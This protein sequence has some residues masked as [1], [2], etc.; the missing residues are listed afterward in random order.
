[1][2]LTIKEVYMVDLSVKY[3]GLDLKNPVVIS[4]HAPFI[5]RRELWTDEELSEWDMEL[6]GKYYEGGVAALTTGSIFSDEM[7]KGRGLQRFAPISTKGFA[8]REAFLGIATMPDALWPHTPG[9]MAIEKAK[10]KFKDM[11][12]IA[13]IMAE[14]QDP[15]AWGNLAL[16]AQQAGA[17]AVECNLGSVMMMKTS[18]EALTGIIEKRG[19][20]SGAIIGLVPEVVAEII[21]GIKKKVS[22]PHITKIT[23]ELGMFGLLSAVPLYK[24]AGTNALECIH[25]LMVVPAPDIYN[26]G[27]TTLPHLTKSTWWALVGPADRQLTYRDVPTVAK[28]FPE[29]DVAACG[30]LVTPE[31]CIEAM[32][33]GAKTVYL[34]AGIFW[35]GMSFPRKVIKFME[36][37]ME[38]QGYKTVYDFIG[39]GLKYVVEMGEAQEELKKQ[40][41]VVIAAVDYDKCVGPDTCRV[42]IDN[43]CVATYVE[44]E[45]VK[46]DPRRCC[47][48][49]LCVVRC[50]YGARSLI[51]LKE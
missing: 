28:Y 17:D 18:D 15:D 23:P 29:M 36:K 32:M 49:N 19:L 39:L 25:S 3:A 41:G 12:I 9:M 42:C 2:T 1:M 35:N 40:P 48:C 10:K 22:I 45:T 8:E 51:E 50:P 14:G 31:H 16:E 47:G 7:P 21:K 30:G 5:P 24:E 20:P 4:S 13:S 43:W 26:R 27:R 6:W 44:D 37:Y 46:I 33:L 34:S 38:E 11:K